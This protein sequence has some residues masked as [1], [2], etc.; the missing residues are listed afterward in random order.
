MPTEVKITFTGGE[1]LGDEM[2]LSLASSILFGRSHSAD[3]RLKEADVSGR[4]MEF[5]AG[6]DGVYAA[7]I[8]RH[9]FLLNGENVVEGTQWKIAPGDV[10]SLGSRVRIRIDSISGGDAAAAEPVTG[11]TRFMTASPTL[12]TQAP[13]FMESSTFATRIGEIT[14][15]SDINAAPKGSLEEAPVTDSETAFSMK[16]DPTPP[17]PPPPPP[18]PCP[19]S[20]PP[21]DDAPTADDSPLPPL[22]QD[23]AAFSPIEPATSTQTGT[24]EGETVEMK[25]RQ[26]SMDE[27]FRMKR[28]LEDKRRFKHR[29]FGFITLLA[30]ATLGTALFVF[31][32]RPEKWL[33]HPLR[34]GT[35]VADLGQFIVKSESG[36]IEMVIDYPNDRSMTKT[37]SGDSLDVMTVTG[38]DRNVPFRLSFQR[39][40][41]LA[42][43]RLSLAESALREMNA[44]AKGGYEFSISEDESHLDDE[45][46]AGILFLEIENAGSCQLKTQRGTRFFRREY[47]REEGGAKWHGIMVFLRSGATVYR[48]LREIPEDVWPRGKYLLRG[49]INMAFYKGFLSGHWESPGAARLVS[50]KSDD[51]LKA[52]VRS[53][54]AK[55]RPVDWA[56]I[57]AEID[58]LVVNSWNAASEERKEALK[59]LSEFREMKNRFYRELQSRSS[60]ARLN[61]DSKKYGEVFDKCRSAFAGD[62]EDL[63]SR[64][65]NDPKEW[66]CQLKR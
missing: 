32:P 62:T 29:F 47:R 59:I 41:D 28:M 45:S 6:E 34:P 58:T 18:P 10:L 33:S 50:G 19:A 22:N 46:K 14:L 25:T 5:R 8:S 55:A 4:H 7:C 20:P 44:L 37:E 24:G 23:D 2:V 39:R 13:E 61:K 64:R 15:P 30:A 3:V 53:A 31:W 60:V 51:E 56:R 42:E 1:N 57:S 40:T 17:A 43:L 54:L 12:A 66:P 11:E 21:L 27:I 9:G 65:V 49:D 63:R 36:A 48:L 38:R 35:K 52:S 16:L 26:A